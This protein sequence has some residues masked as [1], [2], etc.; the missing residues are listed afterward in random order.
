MQNRPFEFGLLV[1]R[2]QMLH[3]GHQRMIDRAAECCRQVGILIGSSDESGT[4]R[5]PFSY[6]LRKELLEK[7]YGSRISVSPLPDIHV[8][9]VPAWGEY[10]LDTAEQA[11]GV[12]PDL[13]ISGREERR[14]HWFSGPGGRYL[15]ELLIPKTL[16]I[17]ASDCRDALLRGD[18]ILWES[19][20]DPRLHPEFERLSEIVTAAKDRKETGSI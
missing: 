2:F 4:F 13:F 20:T 18:R 7:V 16:E 12:R 14:E 11:F 19:L 9:N 5:N 6:E 17:S 10:V 15:N 3:L 1:G 8:G